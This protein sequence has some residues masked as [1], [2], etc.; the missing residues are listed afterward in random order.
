MIY[1]LLV[2]LVFIIIGPL[3]G[4]IAMRLVLQSAFGT[5]DFF[6]GLLI[7]YVAGVIPAFLASI[8]Y[9]SM[10]SFSLERTPAPKPHSIDRCLLLGAAS[11]A[12]GS[13]LSFTPSFIIT[14]AFA[15]AI[16]GLLCFYLQ[17]SFQQ[18]GVEL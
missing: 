15:G 13:A 1:T 17:P 3:V 9:H 16:C 2:V 6:A 8:C 12:V 11:G 10:W 7:G 14:G 5:N 4:Y 18:S